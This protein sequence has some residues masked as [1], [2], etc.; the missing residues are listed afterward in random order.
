MSVP[1]QHEW[2]EQKSGKQYFTNMGKP[3]YGREQQ[4]RVSAVGEHTVPL[5][6]TL[7]DE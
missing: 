4:H 5:S 3:L 1:D 7:T 2:L 6:K